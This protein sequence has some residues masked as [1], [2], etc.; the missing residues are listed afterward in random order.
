MENSG[1]YVILTAYAGILAAVTDLVSTVGFG[2]LY[3]GYSWI[4]DTVSKL[5]AT[6]S[7]V[8][9]QISALWIIIGILLI[10]FGLG[11]RKAFAG[12]GHYAILVS[13]LIVLYGLGEG[14]GSGVFKAD[15]LANALTTSGFIH[16]IF[17][18]VGVFAILL[19]PLAMLKIIPET[20]NRKMYLLA[21]F[22]FSGGII[23]ILL[24][25]SRY[26][27]DSTNFISVY[28]GLW[29]RLFIL[30]SYIYLIS[31]AALIIY[32][33]QNKSHYPEK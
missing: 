33:Q 28:K 12:K 15:R 1:K 4:N 25:L 19:F 13:W 11:F 22:A 17:G 32:R 29:Q 8:S 5:G 14:I 7:P 10:L 6:A 30:I 31:I 20:E 26:S 18:S 21:K 27:A 2:F 16:E 3:P 23:F 9:G 24:F